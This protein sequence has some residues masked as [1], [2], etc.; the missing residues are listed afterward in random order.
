MGMDL[1]PCV[2]LTLLP[3]LPRACGDG[4][5]EAVA[6]VVIE[7]ATPRLWGWTPGVRVRSH[8][9]LGYPAPVGMDRPPPG[10]WGCGW[11]LPRACGDGPATNSTGDFAKL[12]TPRLWGW[13]LSIRIFC[14]MR[15]GYPAPVG[16]DL[17]PSQIPDVLSGLPRACGDG[18][19][20]SVFIADGYG[21]T[22]RLWGWTFV[23]GVVVVIPVGYPAPVG[24]DLGVSS[25][26]G[27]F[28]GLPRA[29]GDGPSVCPHL[30][31]LE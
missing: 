15:S 21:A 12:A 16:M 14:M 20:H 9:A 31:I 23:V 3:W 1:Q 4:P 11:W 27:I 28:S 22:P 26:S 5:A 13:T 6:G 17:T 8:R 18:P 24:M 29:C 7:V 10:A 25:D 2:S 30:R 19:P